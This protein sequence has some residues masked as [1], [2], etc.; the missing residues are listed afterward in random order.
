MAQALA[1]G[2]VKSVRDGLRQ[3]DLAVPVNEALRQMQVCLRKVRGSEEE[4]DT[5]IYKF[6]ALRIWS[7]CS[8]LFFTLNPHGIKS[9]L[10]ILMLQNDFKFEKKCSLDFTDAE[11]AKYTEEYLRQDPRRLNRLIAQDPLVATRVFHWTVRLVLKTLFNC[12]D[13]PGEN[14]DGIAAAEVPGVFGHVRAYLGVVEPQMRKALH[15][16]MLVQLLGFSHPDDL[17]K[18]DLLETTF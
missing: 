3:T 13:K 8:S 17:F 4:R 5:L 12:C 10:S 6:R 11:A 2:D 15:I 18:T 1:S 9:P 16:H 14:L 7:G